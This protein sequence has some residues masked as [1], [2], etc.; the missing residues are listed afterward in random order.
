VCPVGK[1]YTEH[2]GHSFE[3]NLK[4]FYSFKNSNYNT[5]FSQCILENNR[6]FRKMEVVMKVVYYNQK[7]H[8]LDTVEKFYIYK[9]TLKG[10]QLNDKHI[11]T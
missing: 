7:C 10:D 1:I 11:F 8:H 3:K 2:N 5:I 4:N 9:E 6:S